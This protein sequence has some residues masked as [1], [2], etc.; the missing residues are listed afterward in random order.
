[1]STKMR[2]VDVNL[3]PKEQRPTEISVPAMLFGGAIMIA[4][5]ALVTLSLGAQSA[6]SDARAMKDQ[7]NVAEAGLHDVQLDLARQRALSLELT[8]GKAD[9]AALTKTQKGLQGGK[10]PL[11]E[12]FLWLNGLGFLTPGMK[13]TTITGTAEGFR[14]DGTAP[15]TLDAIAYAEK[16]STTGG[17]PS[18]R[19]SSFAPGAKQGGTFTVEVKR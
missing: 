2:I 8:Q 16:L 11:W 4:I 13:L 6:R 10:R 15:G 9:L 12:D 19:V 18:A 14:V 17:F 3:L 5:A 1:M 7:A